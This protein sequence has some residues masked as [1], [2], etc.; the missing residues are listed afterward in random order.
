MTANVL[1]SGQAKETLAARGWKQSDLEQ[2]PSQQAILLRAV[3]LF[4]EQ[5]DQQLLALDWPEPAAAQ[6]LW[7][8]RQKREQL[9]KEL[10]PDP[11]LT[12][13]NLLFPASEKVWQAHVR[14]QQRL[15]LFRTVEAVRLHA[16]Q[17]DGKLPA[18][19]ADVAWPIP[20][21][22]RNRQSF[23]YEVTPAGFRLFSPA[24]A[25]HGFEPAIRY[26]VEIRIRR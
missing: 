18:Q 2:M 4:R 22:E 1:L 3:W 9:K 14:W 7:K 13:L 5:W 23:G 26:E 17:N 20:Q 6:V 24:P 11:F 19:L 8:Q 25:N 15:A 12:T 16:A 10:D 21:D